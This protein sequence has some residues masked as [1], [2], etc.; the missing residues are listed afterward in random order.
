MLVLAMCQQTLDYLSQSSFSHAVLNHHPALNR[1]LCPHPLSLSD[2][3]AFALYSTQ[4]Q[5]KS[6]AECVCIDCEKVWFNQ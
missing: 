6:K 5:T 4:I 1:Y 2:S 3:I